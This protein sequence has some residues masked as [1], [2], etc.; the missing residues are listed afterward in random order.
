MLQPMIE[1]ART[2]IHPHVVGIA[3]FDNL[4]N[5]TSIDVFDKVWCGNERSEVPCTSVS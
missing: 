3:I 2:K 5:R 1:A 4:R